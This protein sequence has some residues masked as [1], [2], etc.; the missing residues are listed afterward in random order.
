MTLSSNLKGAIYA[1]LAF[2]VYSTHDVLVRILGSSFSPLQTL[3]FTSLLS[4]PVLTLLL[5][6]DGTEDNLRPVHPWWTALRSVIAVIGSLCGFYAFANLPF[7]QVYAMIFMMP[8]LVTLF[9][10][11][12]LGERV[13]LH[14]GVAIALGLCG[15]LV[16]IQP[17]SSDLT[18]AHLAGIGIALSGALQSV[19][20]RKIGRDE[21]P[22]VMVLFPLM[23]VFIVTG[24]AL[25]HVYEPMEYSDL[26]GMAGVAILGFVAAL[27]L[28]RA[29]R[30]GEAA[31]VAPM[32]Y[33]QIIWAIL[34]ST[35]LFGEAL[36][37][38]TLI[39]ASI[40]ILSGIYIVA[41]ET[42][43]AS[44]NRPVTRTRSRIVAPGSFRISQVLNLSRSAKANEQSE[45][46]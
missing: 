22:I 42:G 7:A 2:A 41:R 5:V 14:R 20:A 43:G 12:M 24:V 38:T 39:G 30:A 23:A 37:L 15:V 33:S 19:I 9:A 32:Q 18:F 13:G 29:Y 6:Q 45:S 40:V 21:R 3:F 4:F 17:G 1:L 16:V 26:L 25:S 35:L 11:P 10:I 34:F 44:Q 27:L 8:L 31:I 28:V 46:D 36:A